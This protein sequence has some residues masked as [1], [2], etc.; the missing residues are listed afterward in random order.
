M[1]S[2]TN[3]V[4]FISGDVSEA[5]SKSLKPRNN[6]M[7]KKNAYTA[8]TIENIPNQALKD[9]LNMKMKQVSA[10]PASTIPTIR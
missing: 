2:I 9:F 1:V 8:A 3:K 10:K 5:D 7:A 6:F 4:T